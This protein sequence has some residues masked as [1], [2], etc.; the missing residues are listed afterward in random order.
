[1]YLSL[2]YELYFNLQCLPLLTEVLK[3]EENMLFQRLSIDLAWKNEGPKIQKNSQFYRKK[4][5]YKI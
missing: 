5:S 1:M 4:V 3:R 2:R